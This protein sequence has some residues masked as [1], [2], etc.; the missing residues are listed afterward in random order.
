MRFLKQNI[1]LK[2]FALGLSVLFWSVFTHESEIGSF[3]NVPVEY[4]RL[5][6]E[7]EI[8]SDLTTTVSLELRGTQERLRSFS[9]LPAGPVFDFSRILEPGEH[10]F[11]VDRRNVELPPGLTLVRAVPSQIRFRFERRVQR[12]V[13]VRVRFSGE[14]PEGY[15]V[16]RFEPDPQSV[17]IVGPES[18]VSRVEFVLTDPI[19]LSSVIG[20]AHFGVNAYADE[21]MVRFPNPT[22]ITVRVFVEKE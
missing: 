10:T 19:N 21:P 1:G 13:P 14:P 7:L 15:T 9:A 6:E 8:V 11:Q 17:L 18:H 16:T 20:Q 22:R 5:P 12:T 4:R 2:L 3:V